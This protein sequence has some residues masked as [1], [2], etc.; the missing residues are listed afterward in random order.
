MS[1][2]DIVKRRFVALLGNPNSG[3]TTLFNALTG[4]RQKVA[5][6]PGVTVEKKEGYLTAPDGSELIL[7]DLPGIYSLSAS[8]PDEKIA[9]DVLLGQRDDTPPPETVICVVD[10]SNLDRNLYLVSQI[11][12]AR[13]PV[14]IALNMVDVAKEQGILVDSKILERQLDVP[15]IP[16][17][18]SRG[19][20]V[21]ELRSKLFKHDGHSNNYHQWRVPEVVMEECVELQALLQQRHHYKENAAFNEAVLL[22]TS[23][24]AV[25]EHADRF[26][27]E[28]LDHLRQDYDRLVR[29]GID[30]YSVVVEARYKWIKYVCEKAVTHSQLTENSIT[31]AID[32][33]LT[34]KIFGY[35]FLFGIMLL[36]FLTIFSLAEIPMILIGEV[37]SWFNHQVT[38]ILLP[39][40]LRDLLTEGVIT[41]VGAVVAF[42]PQ[43]IILFFFIGLLEDT[44]YMSRAVFLMDHLMKKVGL[45]G[46]SFLP[47]L[48][49]FACAIPG[50]MAARTIS[51]PKDRLVTILIAPFISCSARLPVYVLMIAAFIPN[52]Y[53]FGFLSLQGFML[54]SLY[55][56]GI[57]T[58]LA[59]GFLFKK[60]ILRGEIGTFIMELP[61]YKLPSVRSILLQ[62]WER[63]YLFLGRAGTIILGSSIIL[64]FLATYPKIDHGTPSEK[65]QQSYI[66]QVGTVIEP[67]IKPLGFNWKVGIGMLGS[68]VQR[69]IFVSTMATIYNINDAGNESGLSSL[70]DNMRRD[71][72]P[73]TGLPAFTLLTALCV[74][75][76]YVLA[77]QCLSTVAVVKRETNSW[78]WPLIQIGI[79][80]ATAYS[81]TFIVYHV[82]LLFLA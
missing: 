68:L 72:D 2:N 54:V 33:I 43:I 34:H 21:D 26:A 58:A 47:L 64:W 63:S 27:P 81:A 20:G 40:D 56:L 38:L 14:V 4:L 82:G 12:D 41:G 42:L 61:A 15:V 28:I 11:I 55:L 75:V 59:F 17:I 70:R 31:P 7:I 25:E 29:H 5:N 44:G 3:K 66:G 19:S 52:I 1:K 57:L 78:K 39:G 45:H 51:N 6:Y 67:V 62:M 8:S 36:M 48:S 69:E 50:I 74:L 9:V 22:L 16:T 46:K 18:G 13:I 53:L 10:A 77:M 76:Y 24:L 35:I 65:L 37:F 32:R 80:T 79:M 73:V 23:P 60:T 49:S 71:R 30:R